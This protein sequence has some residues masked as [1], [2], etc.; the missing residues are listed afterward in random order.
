M[1]DCVP[2]NP[3]TGLIYGVDD[4]NG[5]GPLNR[6]WQRSLRPAAPSPPG[7]RAHC[8]RSRPGPDRRSHCPADF[9][10]RQGNGQCAGRRG[11]GPETEIRPEPLHLHRSD[12]KRCRREC[13]AQPG[14]QK[15][16][17]AAL[18]YRPMIWPPATRWP[19]LSN[20]SFFTDQPDSD[21]DGVYDALDK[22]PGHPLPGGCR[23]GRMP[24]GFRWRR[25]I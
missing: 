9:Q 2:F 10:R 17:T 11:I 8:R 1:A 3:E 5:G 13:P 16:V 7:R 20:R 21:G 12:R 22:C 4:Y 14:G 23:C 6:P 19:H 15:P 24:A 18:R 25:G